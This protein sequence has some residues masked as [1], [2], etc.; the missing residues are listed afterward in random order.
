MKNK[1]G[2]IG[3]AVVTFIFF[4]LIGMVVVNLIKPDVTLARNS[5]NLD[6]GNTSISD[7]NKLTCLAVDLTIPY[8]I[9]L[10]CAVGLSIITEKIFTGGNS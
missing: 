7:G 1:R 9:V 8:F 5:A 4:F 2:E 3:F 10:I 6:C